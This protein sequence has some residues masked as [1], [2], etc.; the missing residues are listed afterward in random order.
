MNNSFI[1][2]FRVSKRLTALSTVVAF[3][4]GGVS[5]MVFHAVDDSRVGSARFTTIME[6]NVLLADMLPPPLS[7]LAVADSLNRIGSEPANRL[8]N[9]DLYT[10][11]KKEYEARVE[12]WKTASMDADDHEDLMAALEP[13]HKFI[14]LMDSKYVPQIQAGKADEFRAA[15]ESGELHALYT[16]SNGEMVRVSESVQKEIDHRVTEAVQHATSLRNQIVGSIGAIAAAV[17]VLNLLIAKSISKPLTA[18]LGKIRDMATGSR[19]LTQ[20]LEVAGK[21]ELTELSGAFNTFVEQLVSSQVESRRQSEQIELQATEL[22]SKAI[23][24]VKAT[25]AMAQGRFHRRDRRPGRRCHG[26]DR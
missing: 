17:L 1:R 4:M 15:F 7:L 5:V 23:E 6:H 18:M 2:N 16:K 20:R 19:D 26:R 3:A 14:E 11:W 22:K 9:I 24:L 10:K 25:N 13:A 8:A 12:Y 21:D